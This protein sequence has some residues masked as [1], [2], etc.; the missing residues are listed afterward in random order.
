MI[1][2]KGEHMEITECEGYKK[3]LA[4]VEND[5]AR[6][7]KFHDY[8]RKL[9][10]TIERA[11]HYAEKTDLSA[12]DILDAWERQR[13]YWYMNYYQDCNQ[14]LLT[15]DH[16]RVFETLDELKQAIGKAGFRC[17][18]CGAVSKSPY[19]CDSG[20]EMEPGEVCNWKVYGL[21]RDLGKGIYIFVKA[22]MRGQL[23]FMPVAWEDKL[24]TCSS[25]AVEDARRGS[26]D[27]AGRCTD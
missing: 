25:K 7:P 23:I 21:F 10:W 17:P 24:S 27:Q 16:V 19:E 1:L 22:E 5:E 6:A 26:P 14:P 3:L 4:A 2:S 18:R 8:R 13:S 12:S 15:S 9:N 11:Q 20:A